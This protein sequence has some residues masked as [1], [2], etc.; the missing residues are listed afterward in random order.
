MVQRSKWPQTYGWKSF[1]A[2]RWEFSWS[3]WLG[4]L[5]LFH[6][7]SLCSCLG[8][9]VDWRLSSNKEHSK[10]KE[11]EAVHFL[12]VCTLKYQSITSVFF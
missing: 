9:L 1:L 7:S 8:F 11:A 4:T 2:S 3:W 10:R 5:V 12:K 6:V